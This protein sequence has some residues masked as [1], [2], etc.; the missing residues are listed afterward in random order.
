MSE[1]KELSIQFPGCKPNGRIRLG[2]GIASQLGIELSALTAGRVLFVIDPV[3][4]SLSA[5]L[6]LLTSVEQAG[7]AYDIFS[8]VQ[9]EPHLDGM[10]PLEEMLRATAYG[11]VVGLGGGSAL[12]TA[13]LV[14]VMAYTGCSAEDIFA[15]P[16][17][18][19]GSLPTV[20]LPTT[21]GTGSEVSPYS[22][23]SDG[24][25][26]KFINS[27]YLY[28]TVAMVDP[29]LTVSMPPRVTA[30]TGLDAL[31]H[32][33]EGMIG[34]D[35]PYT[36]ALSLQCVELVFR[37]LPQAVADGSD[38]EARYYLS[39]ASVLG[40]LAYMQGGG[41]Y[42]HS[43]SYILT[44]DHGCPHGVGCGMALPYTLQLN[45]D[46]I[47][48]I[49]IALGKTLAGDHPLTADEV[50]TR[51]AVL[52]KTVGL[53]CNL[54][55]VGVTEAELDGMAETLVGRYFRALNPRRLTVADA[56]VFLQAMYDETIIF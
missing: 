55:A 43:L 47:G 23:M 41:L 13:K 54:P 42:A 46:H 48:D 44:T 32:G 24:T 36:R 49:L 7:L 26:K 16:K 4:V 18:I 56:R 51:F 38:R 25:T 5:H 10:K 8:E 12:D 33:V 1:L 29:E 3:I 9:P 15:D 50:I 6:P 35:T 39:L 37:Y 53:P 27:P 14:A 31:T 22:V 2:M 30:A 19:T 45:R 28:A 17:R 21:S 20:L 40:M 11:A 34:K 52:V